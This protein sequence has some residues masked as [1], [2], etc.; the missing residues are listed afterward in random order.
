VLKTE[1]LQIVRRIEDQQF[2]WPF[3]EP[4]D[5]NEVPDYLT[6]IKVPMDLSLIEKRVRQDGYYKSKQMMYADLML[7]VNN[8]K[9]Y[10]DE[11][12]TYVQCAICLEKF[13]GT[14]FPEIAQK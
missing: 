8:C 2:A 11:S 3:R 14:L 9:L 1:L 12:S 4:V 6:V 13:L 10:N 5:I 7:M